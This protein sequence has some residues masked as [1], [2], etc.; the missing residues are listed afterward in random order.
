[1]GGR[2]GRHGPVEEEV[3]VVLGEGALPLPLPR[4]RRRRRS[5][6]P[7]QVGAWWGCSAAVLFLFFL[8]SSLPRPPSRA[9]TPDP[10]DA[11]RSRPPLAVSAL[12]W[13][14]AGVAAAEEE[15]VVVVVGRG[16]RRGRAGCGAGGGGIDL[17]FAGERRPGGRGY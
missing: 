4:P 5:R 9:P 8:F 16:W 15:D 1:V 17:G 6:H 7:R 2:A 3:D 13:W 11:R 10:R 14:A 12:S